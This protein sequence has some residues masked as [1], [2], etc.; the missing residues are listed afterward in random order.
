[1]STQYLKFLAFAVLIMMVIIMV[2]CASKKGASTS[3]DGIQLFFGN[4]GGFA[5]I[6]KEYRLHPSGLVQY[7][8]GIESA[9]VDHNTVSEALA[10]QLFSQVEQ[11]D[12]LSLDHDQPGNRY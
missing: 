10:T 9:W 7:K 5:G 8:A 12:L 3:A 2:S 1:M 4:G 6:T 11:F